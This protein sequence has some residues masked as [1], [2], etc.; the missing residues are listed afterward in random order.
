MNYFSR[1]RMILSAAKKFVLSLSPVR[2]CFSRAFT[3]SLAHGS[4]C[5]PA[6]GSLERM[7]FVRKGTPRFLAFEVSAD[8]LHVQNFRMPVLGHDLGPKPPADFQV[9]HLPAL[10]SYDAARSPAQIRT[11]EAEGH[12]RLS[13]LLRFCDVKCHYKICCLTCVRDTYIWRM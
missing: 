3:F 5:C 6:G 12:S 11:G 7:G 2:F 4:S 10:P 9:F 13:G 8:R 1:W